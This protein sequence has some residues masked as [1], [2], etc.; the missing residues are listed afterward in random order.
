MYKIS[1]TLKDASISHRLGKNYVGACANIH[2]HTYHFEIIVKTKNL[3]QYDMGID[4]KNI[5][6]ICDKF[7]QDNWDHGMLVSLSDESLISFLTK[8][9]MKFYAMEGNTT[10]ENMSEFL[11]RQFFKDL[12]K[13]YKIETITMKVWET[14]T[15]YA[16][17]TVGSKCACK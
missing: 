15:S 10:A 14:E 3:D 13:T 8:E 1:K 7:I 9:K 11:A 6:E 16:E 17:V 2:G 4:F 5:K 12:S